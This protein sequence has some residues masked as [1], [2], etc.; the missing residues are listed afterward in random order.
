LIPS[1]ALAVPGGIKLAIESCRK[2]A[3]LIPQHIRN[4]IEQSASG[5]KLDIEK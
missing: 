4:G 2:I 1:G 5:C 3:I